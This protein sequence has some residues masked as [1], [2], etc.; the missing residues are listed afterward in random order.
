MNCSWYGFVHFAQEI[1][2]GYGAMEHPQ[3]P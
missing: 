3:S 2:I 1:L